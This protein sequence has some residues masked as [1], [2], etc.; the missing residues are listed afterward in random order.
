VK[1]KGHELKSR[2]CIEEWIHVAIDER[3]GEGAWKASPL[4]YLYS[5][6]YRS[7]VS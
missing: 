3:M 1:G 7:L 5:C 2:G 4:F 6:H